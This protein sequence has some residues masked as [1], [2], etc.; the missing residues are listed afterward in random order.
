MIPCQPR[1]IFLW[2]KMPVTS[3]EK[4]TTMADILATPAK[5]N[6]NGRRPAAKKRMH[7]DLTPIV[8]LGFLLITFFILTTSMSKPAVARLIL[9]KDNVSNVDSMTVPESGVLTFLLPAP[10]EIYY[11]EGKNAIAIHKGMTRDARNVLLHKK[12]STTADKLF[13]IIKPSDN[14]NYHDV[15]A[16][17]DEMNICDIRSY[18]F[19]NMDTADKELISGMDN[20]LQ[21]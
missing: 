12:A 18:A 9:P 17:L 16:M 20:R 19:V 10:G 8:D 14:S 21:H 3:H 5:G 4:T 2:K 11:Y 13:I 1:G 15:M 7:V 6:D